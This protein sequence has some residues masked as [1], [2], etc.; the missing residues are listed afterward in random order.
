MTTVLTYPEK[1]V[2]LRQRSTPYAP[3]DEL[4]ELIH[5]LRVYLQGNENAAAIAAP[6]VG[7]QVRL[8]LWK[9][10]RITNRINVAANPR[11]EA[12]R[13]AREIVGREGC[14]SFPGLTVKVRRPRQVR[15]WWDDYINGQRRGS[16]VL[17]DFEARVWQHET[18]HLDG[19]LM[20]DRTKKETA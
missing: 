19:V 1:A 5:E 14:L 10:T 6:Q 12:V 2:E 13:G 20:I 11:F 18:D 7:V 3:S 16:I 8:F 9:S 15:V 17:S 4:H